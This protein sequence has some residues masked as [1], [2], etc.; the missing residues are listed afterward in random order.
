MFKNKYTI[1]LIVII[2]IGFLLRLAGFEFEYLFNSIA[3]ETYQNSCLLRMIQN[4]TLDSNGCPS[5]YPALFTFIH[6]P[7]V[8]IGLFIL[9]LKTNF[10][11]EIF[12]QVM[13]V[14]PLS[15]LPLIRIFSIIVGTAQ[16]FLI[17]KIT[18][19]LFDSQLKGL[20]AAGFMAVSLMPVQMSHSGRPWTLA[21]FFTLL[22]LY[23]A[24]L[25]Y[26]SGQK[27]HYILNAIFTS[28]AI[29]IHY[30]GF[31]S[32]IFV[33]FGHF[34]RKIKTSFNLYLNVVLTIF[35]GALWLFLN[36]T[37]VHSMFFYYHGT[38]V[39]QYFYNALILFKNFALFDPVIFLLFALAL[40]INFRKLLTF[41]YLFLTLFFIFYLCGIVF[42]NFGTAI[43]WS[44]PLIVISIPIAADLLG[45]LKNKLTSSVIFAILIVS[46]FMPSLIFSATWDYILTLPNTRFTAKYWVEKNLPANSKILFLDAT[47]ILAVSQEGA[48]ELNEGLLG[49][50][51]PNSRYLYLAEHGQ[52]VF[53]GYRVVNLGQFIDNRSYFESQSF[54]YYIL[55]YSN[56][57]EY[58]KR[59]ALLP[60]PEELELLREITPFDQKRQKSFDPGEDFPL[61]HLKIIKDINMT[62]PSI[63]I[64]RKI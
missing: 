7:S 40:F 20:I 31:F 24:I 22:T 9:L 56:E 21:L 55:S 2:A 27:R 52:R 32:I 41:E 60:N 19:L 49:V 42:M 26:K 10:D 64:Y 11:L 37:G 46:L 18:K 51:P 50:R 8:I 45:D 17:Y 1:I 5:P 57:S 54:D 53:P 47:S 16:I 58:Q 4:K 39:G 36:R 13:A 59:V 6:L 48:K 61:E 3:D 29:G 63:E 33:F 35:L 62:G 44:L 15:T 25:I 30:G 14:Y 12:K 28:S 23:S 43:R 38:N 34:F